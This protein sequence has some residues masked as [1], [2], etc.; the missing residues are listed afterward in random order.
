MNT[1][2]E[3]TTAIA[4]MV[5]IGVY[6]FFSFY[7]FRT[8]TLHSFEL[9]KTTY[10]KGEYVQVSLK[11]DKHINTKAKV[12]WYIVDGI[13]Y[14]LDSPGI[15]RPKGKNEV[16]VK[17]QVPESILPGKYHLRVEMEYN[18]HPLHQPI[19]VSWNSPEFEVIE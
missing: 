15:S 17:K 11:F 1:R 7:P 6:L 2:L 14:Q 9:D 12:Q 18:I 5:F 4:F 13:V 10:K 3:R 16:E 8:V 19:N